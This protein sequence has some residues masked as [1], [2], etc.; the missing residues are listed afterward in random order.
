MEKAPSSKGHTQKHVAKKTKSCTPLNQ[1]QNRIIV[2]REYSRNPRDQ[3]RERKKTKRSS[4]LFANSIKTHHS[5]SWLA[6]AQKHGREREKGRQSS[7]GSPSCYQR[8]IGFQF[9]WK[10]VVK[11]SGIHIQWKVGVLRTG[12]LWDIRYLQPC[13]EILEWRHS[14]F[15]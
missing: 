10:S 5:Y 7:T 9:Q 8:A 15:E 14:G 12:L 13:L 4:H 2:G 3:R 11:A 1:Q 6:V